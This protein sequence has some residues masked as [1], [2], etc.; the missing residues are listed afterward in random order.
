MGH[1][2][3]M[4]HWPALSSAVNL[5]ALNQSNLASVRMRAAVA[6]S[7]VRAFGWGASFGEEVPAQTT[8]LV[9][10]KV[11]ASDLDARADSWLNEISRIR[12]LGGKI[13]LDYTDHHLG[14]ESEMSGFYRDVLPLIDICICPS[15]SM[16]SRFREFSNVVSLTVEDALEVAPTEPKQAIGAVKTALWFG[17]NSNIGY[18]IKFLGGEFKPI[19]NIRLIVL[20]NQAGANE[21][22]RTPRP[23]ISHKVRIELGPWS[24][25]NMV[26]AGSLSD[27]GV[28][29]SDST[30]P[31]KS[32]VSANR[33]ITFLALGLPVAA[34]PVLSYRE[35][36]DYFVPLRSSRLADLIANPL[37]EREVVL[38]AQRFVVPRFS[39]E[40]LAKAWR[41]LFDE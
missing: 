25:D 14:F 26:L 8:H 36:G 33:L 32:G 24:L 23:H 7:A 37:T 3:W 16:R 22:M 6:L 2:H 10:G 31:R 20:T 13:Y 39:K 17:H 34:D 18:L 27:F 21:L 28:L 15:E 19:E 4:F 35:F 40:R 41:R 11:G 12:Q 29:P 9:V 30:D 38:N 1:L 5:E